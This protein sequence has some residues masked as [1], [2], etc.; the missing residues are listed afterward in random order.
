MLKFDKDNQ[1]W[2]V[3]ISIM[4]CI[5]DLFLN[6]FKRTPALCMLKEA[7]CYL[8]DLTP[9][10]TNPYQTT[11]QLNPGKESFDPMSPS[12]QAQAW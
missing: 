6:F 5:L 1:L 12:E 8:F 7:L 4:M 9:T 10:Y 3:S 2:Y 11:H